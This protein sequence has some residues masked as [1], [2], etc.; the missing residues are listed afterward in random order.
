MSHNKLPNVYMGLLSIFVFQK[1]VYTSVHFYILS[2]LFNFWIL[3]P[4]PFP[5]PSFFSFPLPH[6]CFQKPYLQSKTFLDMQAVPSSV[7]FCSNVVLITSSS[8][9]KFFSFFD[10][11]ISAPTTTGMILLFLMLHVLLILS[12]VVGFS[13]FFPSL[14]C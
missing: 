10:V 13:Q 2:H 7:V 3:F 6:S 12:L 8:S 14:S 1:P 5:S 11:L 4:C 9:I